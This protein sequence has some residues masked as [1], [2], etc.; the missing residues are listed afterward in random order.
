[1][2]GGGAGGGSIFG[3]VVGYGG[4]LVGEGF[5][6]CWRLLN[7]IIFVGGWVWWLLCDRCLF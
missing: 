5:F 4:Y 7:V 6:G 2:G 1:M 3:V